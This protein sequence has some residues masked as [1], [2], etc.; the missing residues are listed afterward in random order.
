MKL[1]STPMKRLFVAIL[2]LVALAELLIIIQLTSCKSETVLSDKE[3][4]KNNEVNNEA[5]LPNDETDSNIE[6]TYYWFKNGCYSKKL[7]YGTWKIISLI[8]PQKLPSMYWKMLEDGTEVTFNGVRKMEG[9]VF[10]VNEEGIE[11]DGIFHPYALKPT[12]FVAPI[13]QAYV[14]LYEQPSLSFPSGYLTYVAFYLPENFNISR[15]DYIR[16]TN[17]DNPY[18]SYVNISDCDAFFIIDADSMYLQEDGGLMYLVERCEE[19][20]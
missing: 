11:Y 8:P 15:E 19:E 10:T 14:G 7:Y 9:K 6:E 3:E 18:E 1:L 4:T 12:T 5:V 13:S 17:P 16:D 2:A 20:Q